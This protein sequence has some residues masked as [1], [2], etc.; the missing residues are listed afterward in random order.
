VINTARGPVIDESALV[1]ALRSGHLGGAGLDTFET[2]PIAADNPL[3][4][5]DNVILTPHVAGVTRAAALKVA[6]TTARNVVDVLAG[7][8]LPPSHLVA[9]RGPQ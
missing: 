2:E 5:L 8:S 6:T 4:A 3:L 7:R 9:R 1:S